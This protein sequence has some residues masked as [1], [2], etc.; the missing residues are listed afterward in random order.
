MP[1]SSWMRKS[2]GVA[3]TWPVSQEAPHTLF[4][5]CQLELEPL[6]CTFF[7]EPLLAASCIRQTG[8]DKVKVPLMFSHAHAERYKNVCAAGLDE[9]LPADQYARNLRRRGL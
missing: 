6:I 1:W 5:V 8:Q 9:R 7:T 3:G 2:R 4:R